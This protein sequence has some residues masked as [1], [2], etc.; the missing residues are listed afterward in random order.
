MV[1]TRTLP[2]SLTGHSGMR[3]KK[4]RLR[5]IFASGS[6]GK[7]GPRGL[8][9]RNPPISL[10][11]ADLV[12][13]RTPLTLT[14]RDL[15]RNDCLMTPHKLPGVWNLTESTT[16]ERSIF[17]PPGGWIEVVDCF[18]NITAAVNGGLWGARSRV[19][20]RRP[21]GARRASGRPSGPSVSSIHPVSE[22]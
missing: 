11:K 5:A 16:R 1:R 21:A 12:N 19:T 4:E 20:G 2:S 17:Q 15:R 3:S 13:L 22:S 8:R 10:R 9:H 6:Q 18:F 14:Y 7:P